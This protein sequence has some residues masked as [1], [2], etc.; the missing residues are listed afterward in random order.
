MLGSLVNCKILCMR[1]FTVDAGQLEDVLVHA[2]VDS[3]FFIIFRSKRSKDWAAGSN[4]P[5]PCKILLS[6]HCIA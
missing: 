4:G 5:S 1:L 6:C 2:L 3:G